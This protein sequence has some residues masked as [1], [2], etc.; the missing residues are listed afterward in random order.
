[1]LTG[2]QEHPKGG[3][4]KLRESRRDSALDVL[5]GKMTEENKNMMDA[6]KLSEVSRPQHQRPSYAGSS[7]ASLVDLTAPKIDA[8]EP[9]LTRGCAGSAKT[10]DCKTG[11]ENQ[12]AWRR[13]ALY[14]VQTEMSRGAMR[15]VEAC[16]ITMLPSHA[17]PLDA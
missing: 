11:F 16:S 3:S 1:M 4:R 5:C 2:F 15:G 17:S 6:S 7:E 12:R 8:I 10:R 13:G 14:D 9:L